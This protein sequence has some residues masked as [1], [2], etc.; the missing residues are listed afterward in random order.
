MDCPS[1]TGVGV[2]VKPLARTRFGVG[3]PLLVM[4]QLMASPP[5]AVNEIGK[6]LIDATFVP[7]GFALLHTMVLEYAV[8]S[9][10]DP[11][12]IASFNV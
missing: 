2:A 4:V 7:T 5:L 12:A 11:A 8:I 6:V 3:V 1:T 9:E 10:P